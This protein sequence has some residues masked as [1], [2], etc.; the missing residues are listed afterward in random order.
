MDLRALDYYRTV[1]DLGSIS[2]AAAFLRIAQ[3]ALSRIIS[4]F[5]HS[6]NVELLQRSSTGVAPT[7]AGR[8]LLE[9]TAAVESSLAEISREVAGYAQEVV[10]PLRI[11][12]QPSLSHTVM[13]NVLKQYLQ[14]HPKVELRVLAGYS[15]DMID[16]LLDE[17]MDVV[18]ADTPSHAPRDITVLPLWVE[19]LHLVGPPAAAD[20]ELFAGPKALLCEALKLP[21]ILPSPRYSLRRLIDQTAA[22]EHLQARPI[23]EVDGSAMIFALIKRGVGYTI[24][25]SL[26]SWSF[27]PGRVCAIETTPGIDRPLS[28][29]VRTAVLTDRKVS[30][31]V[32]L[33]KAAV[34]ELAASEQFRSIRLSF[35]ALT[36]PPDRAP[37]S[38]VRNGP[39]R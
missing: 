7:A 37:L 25:P 19:T 34:A 5:E 9:R 35:D 30:T 3:P 18:V 23:I 15:A 26:G 39:G 20:T 21:L 36:E 6:L 2:K 4:K 1:A 27:A 33:F 13:P 10:G 11:G 14:V 16:G 32:R 22:R 31:F 8:L 17:S 38:V 24:M 29:V 12:V 28:I